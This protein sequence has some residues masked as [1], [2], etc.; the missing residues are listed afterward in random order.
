MDEDHKMMIRIC[1][2]LGLAVA[3][4][5]CSS[6]K[7]NSDYDPAVDFEALHTYRWAP[8]FE[9]AGPTP[10]VD[11]DLLYKRIHAAI[12]FHLK[13]LGFREQTYPEPDVWVAY[14]VGIDR[15]IEVDTMY[16]DHAGWGRRGYGYGGYGYADTVVREYDEGTLLIDLLRPGSGEL[17]WRG[18]GRTRLK[19]LKTPA[20]RTQAVNEIVGKILGQLR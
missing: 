12:D 5:A 4:A 2:A 6:I 8:D 19:E 14:H 7:V 3:L 11:D 10:G 15:K 13:A 16:H 17:I 9:P 1:G 18:S 20:E